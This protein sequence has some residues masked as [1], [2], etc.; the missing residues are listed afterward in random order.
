MTRQE[1]SGATFPFGK[2][3]GQSVDQIASSDKGLSYLDWIVGQDWFNGR[4]REAVEA[5]L[6]GPAMGREVEQAI[7]GPCGPGFHNEECESRRRPMTE[8]FDGISG[9]DEDDIPF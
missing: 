5:Y 1:A 4:I 9:G 7:S 6:D 2:Y 3:K 8:A